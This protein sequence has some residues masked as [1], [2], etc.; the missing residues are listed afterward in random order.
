MKLKPYFIGLH[1]HKKHIV[2]CLKTKKGKI[3]DEGRVGANGWG[4]YL[5]RPS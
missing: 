1:L 3:V 2:N 5:C 4:M